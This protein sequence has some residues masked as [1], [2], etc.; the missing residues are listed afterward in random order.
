MKH[1]E[2]TRQELLI[3]ID[4]FIASLKEHCAQRVACLLNL[5][6]AAGIDLQD[7]ITA[8]DNIEITN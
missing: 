8:L 5:S 7:E 3:S 6:L 2:Y 1:V 4:D